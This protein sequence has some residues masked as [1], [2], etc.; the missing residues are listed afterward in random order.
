MPNS[1]H[2]KITGGEK[3]KAWRRKVEKSLRNQVD[4]IETGFFASARYDTGTPVTNVAAWNEYGTQK[5]GN[6]F[7]GM[8]PRPFMSL[9]ADN[10]PPKILKAAKAGIDKKTCVVD[11]RTGELI[12]IAIQGEIQKAIRHGSWKPNTYITRLIKTVG[13]KNQPRKL[14]DILRFLSR[15]EREGLEPTGNP[16]PLMDT[17]LMLRS[18]TYKVTPRKR[19]I[20]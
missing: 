3:Y 16:Q 8:P 9:A 15:A 19:K 20:L 11:K 13:P 7:N 18:V 2:M 12:G 5:G 4:N 6:R 17:G 10:A 14:S 1:K